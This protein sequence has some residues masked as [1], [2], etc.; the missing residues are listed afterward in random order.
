MGNTRGTSKHHD[1]DDQQGDQFPTFKEALRRAARDDRF[2]DAH[3]RRIDLRFGADGS[4]VYR[5]WEG[6][7][8]DWSAGECP[9]P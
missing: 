8:E 4:G 9:G 7:S 5:V 6:R 3:V 1:Q 2:A